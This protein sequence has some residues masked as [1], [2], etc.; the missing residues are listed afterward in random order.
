M[1]MYE[2]I[3]VIPLY[4]GLVRIYDSELDHTWD[5]QVFV[6]ISYTK[7]L[8]A[9]RGALKDGWPKTATVQ[10]LIKHFQIQ[11]NGEVSFL[12]WEGDIK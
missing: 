4:I 2:D 11:P 8:T 1:S 12:I 10:G 5:E 3:S 6:G 7:A 9:V